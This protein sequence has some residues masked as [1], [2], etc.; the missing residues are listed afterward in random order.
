MLKIGSIRQRWSRTSRNVVGSTEIEE[1]AGWT[2][3][4]LPVYRAWGVARDDRETETA[5]GVAP[6]GLLGSNAERIE[7]RCRE[8]QRIGRGE[9]ANARAKKRRW[10]MSR[11]VEQVGGAYRDGSDNGH[12]SLHCRPL[13]YIY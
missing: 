4:Y 5:I 2:I 9:S 7:G 3:W 12:G 11:S 13:L 6:V 8:M 1:I 10:K